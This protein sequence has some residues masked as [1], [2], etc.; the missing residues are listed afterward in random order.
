[1]QDNETRNSSTDLAR[2]AL[3]ILAV[4]MPAL[5]AQAYLGPGLGLGT[6]IVILGFLVSIVLAIVGLFWYPLKRTVRKWRKT[7]NADAS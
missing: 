4:L 2:V 5:P 7:D 6:L 3:V 1:M